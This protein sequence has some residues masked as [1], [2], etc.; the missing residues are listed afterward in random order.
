MHY[1][2]LKIKT[3]QTE[4]IWEKFL[5]VFRTKNVKPQSMP[6]AQ[7]RFQ[8]L[9]FDPVN[10]KSVD[11]P[12]ELRKLAKEAFG[13]TAHAI[14]EHLIFAKTPPHLKKSINQAHSEIGTIEQFAT[15]RQ[16]ELE[17]KDLEALVSY[18]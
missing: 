1:K 13:I 10:Q 14:N 15:Q 2:Q 17:L 4:R 12:D 6:T 11:F 18:K 16:R 5:A 7:H 8:K 9:V 3:T